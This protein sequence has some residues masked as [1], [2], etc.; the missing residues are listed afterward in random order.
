MIDPTGRF[1]KGTKTP[2]SDSPATVSARC[3]ERG[4]PA[5]E[6]AAAFVDP[7]GRE[8]TGEGLHNTHPEHAAAQRPAAGPGSAGKPTPSRP[9]V[10]RGPTRTFSGR[11]SGSGLTSRSPSHPIPS[12]RDEAPLRGGQWQ[13]QRD[14]GSGGRRYLTPGYP[15][16]PNTA[17][18]PRRICRP[19]LSTGSRRTSLPFSRRAG[20]RYPPARRP[21]TL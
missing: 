13:M 9:S 21:G 11:S 20:G 3:V 18:R 4:R 17:A 1:R 16:P 7:D 6:T 8:A 19:A 14:V 10:S 2:G 5:W 15:E 12:A